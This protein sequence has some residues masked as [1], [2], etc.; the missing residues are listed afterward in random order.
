M[1]I[2]LYGE[3]IS[4]R[5]TWLYDLYEETYCCPKQVRE[6]I[7]ALAPDEE[8]VLEVNSPGGDVY[9]GF[10]IY[11]ML[12]ACSGH[13]EAHVIALAASAATTITSAC[14]TV[15][16]SPVA[17]IMIHQP[18]VCVVDYV[19]N[20]YAKQL[21]NFLDSIKASIVNGYVKKSAGKA[22]R[23]KLEQL[24]D[25]STYMPVQD[26]IELGLVDGI[27]DAEEEDAQRI[28]E[29]GGVVVTNFALPGST[30]TALLERYEAAVRAGTMQEVPEHPVSR[31]TPETAQDGPQGAENEAR[32]AATDIDVGDNWRMQAA[33]D[34][35]RARCWP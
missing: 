21:K 12:Q 18:S 2:M 29:G 9:A 24:V 7:K 15:L 17:Q 14:D 16:A 30:P 11:G 26:A 3:L 8:L 19:N 4:D 34:L 31:E 22:T 27:L 1:K 6:A 5:W 13:T 33:I 28:R 10:E 23:A 20:E 35:E 32:G 25:E